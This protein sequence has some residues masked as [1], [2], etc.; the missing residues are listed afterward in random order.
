MEVKLLRSDIDDAMNT[1][2]EQVRLGV[3][4][5]HA[6]HYDGCFPVFKQIFVDEK[7]EEIR[8]EECVIKR[9][10]KG[11]L[12]D[13]PYGE[14]DFFTYEE[15]SLFIDLWEKAQQ[16]VPNEVYLGPEDMDRIL[17]DVNRKQAEEK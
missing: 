17:E 11:F 7:I 4:W 5:C 16:V 8:S 2:D 12:V 14:Q 9:R 13:D 15:V 1:A 10:E 3:F 6:P